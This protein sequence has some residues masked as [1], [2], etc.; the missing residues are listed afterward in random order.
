MSTKPHSRERSPDASALKALVTTKMVPPRSAGRIVAR[1][2]LLARLMEA[3]RRRCL[4]LQGPAGCGKTTT[5]VAWRQAL[6]PLGFDVAWLTLTPED[7]EL[8]RLLDYLLASLGQVA[9]AVTQE[10]ADFAGR[11]IDSEAVERTLIALVRSIAAHPR[12]LV[13]VLDD[14]HHLDDSRIHEALQWLIDYAP[15][16]LHLVLAS[17]GAVPLSL[18]RLRTEGQVLELDVRDLR[19]S[20]AESARF[21]QSQLGSIDHRDAVLLHELSDGWA[22]GLQLL[23][24]NWKKRRQELA[25]GEA[26]APGDFVRTHVQDPQAFS[27][28]FE[29]EVLSRLSPLELDL[30]ICA[31][32]CSR[33]CAPLCAALLGRPAG[34]PTMAPLLARLE[35]ENLFIVPVESTERETWYRLHPLLR[36][37]LRERLG[38][39]SEAD[40]VRVHR[41]A[42]Q[43]FRDH[44]LID[45]A[46]RQAVAAGECAAAAALVEKSANGLA[47]RGE[48]R[49]LIGLVRQL[50]PAQVEARVGLRLWMLRMEL[51]ARQFDAFSA[52]VER[53]R[54][55]IPPDDAISHFALTMQE[56]SL[57]L[58][59]DDTDAAMA[60]LPRLLALP[61]GADAMASGGRDNILSW[62]FM[63][64][65][66]FERA[67]RVQQDNPIRLVDGVP[68][69][70][71]PSGTL[72][73]RCLVGL[74]YALEGRMTQAE[75]IYREVLREANEGGSACVDPAYLA[76]ALLGEVLYEHDETEAVLQLL[77]DRV[78]ALERVSIPDSV[79]RV[80]RTLAAA[81][82]AAGRRLEGLAYLERLEDYSASLGLDRLLVHSLTMQ[83]HCR[84]QMGDPAAAETALA[85]I[86]EIDA[87][88]ADA[89]RSALGEIA[90]VAER[91]R[92]RWSLARG[93]LDDAARRIEALIAR[94]ETLG[95]QRLVAQLKL[96]RAVI[97]RRRGRPDAVRESTLAALRSGHRLGLV[98]SLLDADPS[99]L[100]LVAEIAK[101]ASLDPVLAFYAE[102]LGRAA[103][104]PEGVA[105]AAV[106]ADA[107]PGAAKRPVEPLSERE[108]DVLALLAQAMP[109]KK[110]ALA[111]GLSIDTVKW[112]LKNIYGKLGVAGRDEAV[113]WMRGAG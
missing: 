35:A 21:L 58:Q 90:V 86:D 107:A 30:L 33:F 17:R 112:H 55:D 48:L 4:V 75:R 61:E 6:L 60:L 113:A 105:A 109:N 23:A 93:D 37:T 104:P 101:D 81:H 40:R 16:N 15:S 89:G 74:S 80:H 63:H 65:G 5:L 78:D 19:F 38:Q 59:R 51:F 29:K 1:D 44:G 26:K 99:V 72:Q 66:D 111:L 84:L 103:R 10:A 79:L 77:E 49:K 24:I 50:P 92:I 69:R 11:G 88:H 47:V 91:A 22:A 7:N 27:A 73:G 41:I 52:H 95:R 110:I 85:R 68:L 94:I 34:D 102:R 3:R 64:R 25:G 31:S 71:T 36:E 12:D 56:A 43:W 98:R 13:L 42:W 106:P 2:A 62:L 46:V 8:T 70:G 57:A 14:L 83:V 45:E 100:D 28:Y 53:L 39:R 54:P 32:A 82:W 67:R 108:R 18:E 76:T 87:R 96:M 20:P 97:E 9:P